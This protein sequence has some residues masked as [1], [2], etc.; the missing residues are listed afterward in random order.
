MHRIAAILTV[1]AL[2]LTILSPSR[3]LAAIDPA[4]PAPGMT[5]DAAIEHTQEPVRAAPA[6]PQA[7][8]DVAAEE[9][10][11]LPAA[12]QLLRH[13]ARPDGSITTT[14]GDPPPGKLVYSNTFGQ[15][16]YPPLAN[17]AI[18]DDLTTTAVGTCALRQFMVRVGGRVP[19]GTG[20]FACRVRLFD[21]CPSTSGGQVIP[22]TGF[23]FE[24]LSDSDTAWH[25]LVV[26]FSDSPIP[27]PPTVWLEV[28]FTTDTAGIV[29]GTLPEVG[30]SARQFFH[31]FLG[32]S[33]I[34]GP[35]DGSIYASFYAR[36]FVDDDCDT[37]H[38]TYSTTYPGGPAFVIPG[39]RRVA[40]DL[41][42]ITDQC[43]LSSY[44]LG[45][46]GT[47][48]AFNMDIDLRLPNA[49]EPIPGTE[50]T[51]TGRGQGSLE[52][53]RF[54]FPPGIF[55]PS[56][57]WASWK[58]DRGMT[59]VVRTNTVHVGSSSRNGF[60]FEPPGL[61]GWQPFEPIFG[62][63]GYFYVNVF[64]RGDAP[65]GA[66]CAGAPPVEPIRC[67]DPYPVTSCQVGR[68]A[69]GNTCA[70]AD[71]D[72][73]CG[74]YA[75]CL[76]SNTC[77]YFT[78]AECTGMGGVHLPNEDCAD[79]PFTCG[80]HVCHTSE[81]SCLNPS[82]SP[83]CSF[84]S[85]CNLVCWGDDHCCL[86]EWDSQCVEWGFQLGLCADRVNRNC[87][88]SSDNPY[89]VEANSSTPTSNDHDTSFSPSFG[90]PI[91]CCNRDFTHQRAQAPMWFKFVATHTSARISSCNSD[92]S[93]DK[94][95]LLQVYRVTDPT[96]PCSGLHAIACN[97]DAGCGKLADLCVTGLTPGNL[98]VVVLGSKSSADYGVFR[99]DIQ[100]PCPDAMLTTACP[101]GTIDWLDPVDGLIDARQPHPHNDPHTPQGI[102]A[103]RVAAP[104]GADNLHCWSVC[105]SDPNGPGNGIASVIDNADGT[106]TV[107]LAAPL[108]PGTATRVTYTST[109]GCTDETA[110]FTAHPGDV[111]ADG[112]SNARD[113][114][115]LIDCCMNK[116]CTP[117]YGSASC[118]I[119]RSTA[120]NGTDVLRLIDL[121]NG[122]AAYRPWFGTRAS[123]DPCTARCGGFAGIPCREG[124]FCKLPDGTCHYADLFGVCRPMG[125]GCPAVYDPVC[126]CD[127]V[128]YS[129]ECEADRAGVPVDHPGPCA[130]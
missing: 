123:T 103:L 77:E 82:T 62:S 87:R 90:D 98:Y 129:N 97:D 13:V 92:L 105:E 86:E 74:A 49:I 115:T 101:D 93:L 130:P 111:N 120:D 54:A 6:T 112:V 16:L 17:R 127:G 18:A 56:E 36:L 23:W 19:N 84:R 1:S 122:A 48:G 99:L 39:T 50:R 64:C 9:L 33:A 71:F 67:Y 24:H 83:G 2:T 4:P 104:P 100:S 28:M 41:N 35:V 118:D 91:L 29:V 126:G 116:V 47:D 11:P 43:E 14:A 121:L 37:H 65:T 32:C 69:Q 51:Y 40:D 52:I 79:E 119:N 38:I 70:D 3:T 55:V 124:E 113:I 26:D 25:D 66:C 7:A 42:L 30:F 21:G 73:P 81:D 8:Q 85:C 125:G 88:G 80:F 72:P 59:G 107:H 75:C 109:S 60:Q 45:I 117:R 96:N 15:L 20:E 27:I 95:T 34:V 110:T 102:Q 46:R 128:T 78:N 57:V 22:G 76:P 106:F 108:T 94:D 114:L 44:E 31:Q 58:P 68:W 10:L 12:T 61:T 89:S 63:T 53:A 5:A